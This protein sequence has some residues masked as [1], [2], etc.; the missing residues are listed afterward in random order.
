MI[1]NKSTAAAASSS[2]T[3][4]PTGQVD[5][6]KLVNKPPLLDCK[7]LDDEIRMFHDWGWQLIQFLNTIDADY[8]SELQQIMDKPTV[9]LDMSTGSTETRKRGTKL[10]GL[11]ASLCRNRSLSVVRSANNSDG[12]EALR[13]LILTLRPTTN[14]R[15]LAL[16]AALTSWP[17]FTM[18]TSLQP[19]IMRLD[20]ALEE[21]RRAGST[22][23]DELKQAILLKCVPGQLRTHLNLA[24]QE[25]TTFKDLREKVVQWDRG[26]QKWNNL[27]IP[28]LDTSGAMEIDRVGADGQWPWYPGKKGNQKGKNLQKGNGAQKGKD[29]GK[30]TSKESGKEREDR[31]E[32]RQIWWESAEFQRKRKRRSG[33]P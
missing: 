20:E 8:D 12:F 6:S 17:A 29:K 31:R 24:I 7:T 4:S 16:T 5:W 25:T 11:L 13:Q 19:Q 3:G 14:N 15:G 9:G 33:M 23:P 21:C 2:P 1:V 30:G 32:Q 10:Y 22:I 26:Q 27:I 28:N 18:N